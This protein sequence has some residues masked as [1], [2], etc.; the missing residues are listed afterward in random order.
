MKLRF[1]DYPVS[2]RKFIGQAS[3]AAIGASTLLSSM[4]NLKAFAAAA[5]ANS[6][7]INGPEYKAL[8]CVFLSGGNDSFNMLMPRD[9]NEYNE[10]ATTRSNLAIPLSEMLPIF[11][12]NTNG[13]LFGLHPSMIRSQQLF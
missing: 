12:E 11:P 13:R 2:R 4:I 6:T 5:L 10:Y 9:T 1:N 8:V 3:C 7:T